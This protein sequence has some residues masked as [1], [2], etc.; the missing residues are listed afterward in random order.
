MTPHHED[1]HHSEIYNCGSNQFQHK[2][3]LFLVP[4]LFSVV[5]MVVYWLGLCE[6]CLGSR[7]GSA[8]YVNFAQHAIFK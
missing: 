8:W 2:V 7:L 6:V 3:I 4:I 1:Q 5:V